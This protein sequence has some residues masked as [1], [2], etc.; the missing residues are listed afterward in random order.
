MNRYLEEKYIELFIII[1]YYLVIFFK[2]YKK[3]YRTIRIVYYLL[4][5]IKKY[6][7][8]NIIYLLYI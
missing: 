2:I 3:N 6:N 8:Y 5:L 4:C 7:K 1:I